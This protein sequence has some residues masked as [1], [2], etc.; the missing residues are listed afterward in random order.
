MT[1]K[2]HQAGN[3]PRWFYNAQIALIFSFMASM[4]IGL[5]CLAIATDNAWHGA[6]ASDHLGAS[7][8]QLLSWSL[9]FELYGG[10]GVT[11][12][13]ILRAVRK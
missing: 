8:D 12:M 13:T 3:T 5:I 2:A 10:V 6:I 7:Q 9:A 1:T 4:V 11:L